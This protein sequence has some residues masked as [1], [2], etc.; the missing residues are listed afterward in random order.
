MFGMSTVE[1]DTVDVIMYPPP[2]AASENDEKVR[3]QYIVSHNS[4]Q[5]GQRRQH[6][7]PDF[8]PPDHEGKRDSHDNDG[9]RTKDVLYW[10]EERLK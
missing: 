7:G 1:E 5:P 3:R 8:Q 10:N 2:T 4:Y 9:K 6:Y